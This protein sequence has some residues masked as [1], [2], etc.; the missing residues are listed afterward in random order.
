MQRASSE[1]SAIPQPAAAVDQDRHAVLRRKRED[2]R[3]PLVG[4]REFL[5]A[6]VQLDPA[7]AERERPL[8]LL[9]RRLVQV[10]AQEGDQPAVASGRKGESAVVGGG[11]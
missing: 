6:R 8:R 11:E 5:S 3:K 10:E 7:G 2:R 1:R 9:D 4:G